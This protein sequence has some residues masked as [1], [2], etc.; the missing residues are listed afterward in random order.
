[1]SNNY[2]CNQSLTELGERRKQVIRLHKKQYSV[3]QIVELAGLS[4][5]DVRTAIDLYEAGGLAAIKPKPRG[6]K[7]GE[8][9]R[10]TPDQAACIQKPILE[11]RREQLK[12]NFALW[13]WAAAGQLSEFEREIKLSVRSVSNYVKRWGFTQLSSH[14]R[15]VFRIWGKCACC[16]GTLDCQDGG[17]MLEGASAITLSIITPTFRR[18]AFLVEAIASVQK[19]EGLKWEMLIGDDLPEGSAEPFVRI[20]NDER[21]RYW[22]NPEPTGG[23][24][25]II[26]NRL[27][28]E[29][30]GKYL[31][32]LDDDDRVVAESL[33]AMVSALEVT[34]PAVAVADVRPFGD[35]PEALQHEEDYFARARVVWAY[36]KRPRAIVMHLLFFQALLVCSSCVIR[37]SAFDAIRGFDVRISICEDIEMYIRAIRSF[38]FVYIPV[39]LLERRCGI[40][41]LIKGGSGAQFKES[42]RIMYANYRAR[43]GAVEFLLMKA[44]SLLLKGRWKLF[45]LI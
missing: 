11:R 44:A 26:R 34:T 3:R 4:W 27:A 13:T 6:K 24:P 43:F 20:L 2:T 10:L 39:T 14:C 21:I 7:N 45:S 25:A 30:R 32:F 15:S 40:S 41:S 8:G 23:F 29:A 42:Y 36:E 9:S 17:G 19:I 37:K 1:M 22:K 31:Y 18:E 38:G 33:M 5:P 28:A 12:M 35:D 16:A